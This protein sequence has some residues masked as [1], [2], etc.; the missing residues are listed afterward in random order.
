[1]ASPIQQDVSTSHI[2]LDITTD[3]ATIN[4]D[5]DNGNVSNPGDDVVTYGMRP[6]Q[7]QESIP[8]P[9]PP[10]QERQHAPRDVLYY[11]DAQWNVQPAT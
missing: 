2:E 5:N 4:D 10:T 3:E 7:P 6:D 9:N 1:M 11:D 8:E